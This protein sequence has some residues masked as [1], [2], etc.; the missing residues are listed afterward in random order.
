MEIG[1][2]NRNSELHKLL[3]FDKIKNVVINHE[4]IFF[5]GGQHPEMF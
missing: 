3:K 2:I 4:S 1:L 5:N